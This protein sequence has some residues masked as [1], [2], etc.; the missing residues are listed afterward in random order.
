VAARPGREHAAAEPAFGDLLVQL[1]DLLVKFGR[2]EALVRERVPVGLGL[3]A[4][5]DRG[6]LVLGGR[7]G[8]GDG[9]VVEVPAFAAL[10]RP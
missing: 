7:V 10:R 4:A 2:V 9:F 8:V 5:G 3:R 6:L 1:A